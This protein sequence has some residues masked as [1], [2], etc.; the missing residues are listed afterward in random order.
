MK[1]KTK[2]KII[3]LVF[4]LLVF[5]GSFFVDKKLFNSLKDTI[6]SEIKSGV[7]TLKKEINKNETVESTKENNIILDKDFMVLFIDVGQADSILIKSQDE[8]MLIDA[9]NNADGPKLVNFFNELS[10]K[11]FKYVFGTH[12]HEDHIG[13]MDNIIKN[14]KVKNFYMPNA[15]TTTQTFLEIL[16]QLE[17]KKIAFKTPNIGTKLKLGESN[18]EIIYV[19]ENEEDLND[20]SIIIKVTYK[21]TSFLFTGDTTSNVE[22]EILDKEIESDVLKV[23]H[24]GSKYSSSA[25]FLNKV[26]PKYAIISCGKNN[27]YGHPHDVILKKLKKLKT[28]IYRTDKLGTIIVISDGKNITIKNAKTDTN[29]E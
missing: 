29:G 27:D 14:F 28:N 10:I 12:A 1:K 3:L 13:G 6:F 20:T 15:T 16:E 22:K 7:N 9:G 17:K 18:I 2:T 26:K 5:A 24:H 4:I 8:Y 11:E 21:N 25:S 23:A 19:G